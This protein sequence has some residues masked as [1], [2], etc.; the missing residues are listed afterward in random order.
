M[1]E[2]PYLIK[3]AHFTIRQAMDNALAD[4]GLTSAQLEVL[5]RV[6]NCDCMEHRTLLQDMDVA[7]P[8]LTKLADTLVKNGYLE[9]KISEDDARVKLLAVTELG[10]ASFVKME[11]K[12]PEFTETLLQGFST[13]ERLLFAELLSRLIDNAEQ[14]KR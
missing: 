8:T 12:F 2:L 3:R 11:Q 13:A 10:K 4:E 9:R 14:V 5:A 7:S 1:K 6:A